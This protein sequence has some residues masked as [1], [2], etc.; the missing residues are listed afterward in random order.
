MDVTGVDATVKVVERF[1]GAGSENIS[2]DGLL[3]LTVSPSA[4][5]P[6]Q[7]QICDTLL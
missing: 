2:F 5:V 1:A 6:Q 3:Q 4:S 7:L